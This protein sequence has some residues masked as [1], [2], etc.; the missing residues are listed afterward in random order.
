MSTENNYFK[1]ANAILVQAVNLYYCDY[2]LERS[3]AE[4]SNRQHKI[5]ERRASRRDCTN[6]C[7]ASHRVSVLRCRQA[8]FQLDANAGASTEECRTEV[9]AAR[10]RS[11]PIAV[12]RGRVP[13]GAPRDC[14]DGAC[15]DRVGRS[16][17]RRVWGET[18]AK[19]WGAVVNGGCVAAGCVTAVRT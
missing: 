1:S 17:R 3:V 19:R 2:L 12:R 8:H 15:S 11:L 6:S 16:R 18:A 7:G 13:S 10:S 9:L 4:W 14:R 5:G